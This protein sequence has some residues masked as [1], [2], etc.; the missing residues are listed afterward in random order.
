VTWA[1]LSSYAKALGG[2]LI[3]F[4]FGSLLAAYFQWGVEKKKQIAAPS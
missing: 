1:D 4:V 3:G 2:P